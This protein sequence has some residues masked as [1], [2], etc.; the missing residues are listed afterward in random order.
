M[1]AM[2]RAD[3]NMKIEGDR[4]NSSDIGI[5]ETILTGVPCRSN[6]GWL[7]YCSSVLFPLDGGWALF[8]TGHYNDRALLREALA[9][10]GIEPDDIRHVIL[11]HLHFDHV[12]NLSLFQNAEVILCEAEIRYAEEVD[13]GLVQDDAIPD[14]WPALLEGRKIHTVEDALIIGKE[15][16]IVRLPGHTPGCLSL[17]YTGTPSVAVCGDVVK[18]GW[19]IVTGAATLQSLD[20]DLS[21]KSINVI[22]QR[23]EV[24]IP[25]HDRAFRLRDEGLEYLGEFS[26]EIYGNVFPR[27]QNEIIYTLDLQRGFYQ[28]P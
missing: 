14:F 12:L 1:T 7:G 26:W 8:D 6:R 10:R 2:T 25:G 5:F 28:R 20:D 18:N 9:R 17:F 24:I 16:E 27:P 15:L 13:A 21:R 22:K 23:G 4:L 19:E 3:E 11:S